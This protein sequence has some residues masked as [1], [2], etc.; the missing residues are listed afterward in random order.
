MNG[1]STLSQIAKPRLPWDALRP[2]G[3][4]L[5]ATLAA[6]A[7]VTALRA[8]IYWMPA[9]PFLLLPV[10]VGAFLGGV[11]S[12]LFGLA[13]VLAVDA[14][15]FWELSYAQPAPA[16]LAAGIPAVWFIA[17]G[18]LLCLAGYWF[19]RAGQS[20]GEL[21]QQRQAL[22]REG[23]RRRNLEESLLRSQTTVKAQLSEIEG[24]FAAAPVGLARVGP[25]LR[26][27][28]INRHWVA[29]TGQPPE[30]QLGRTVEEALPECGAA[31]AACLREVLASGQAA[32]DRE[33]SSAPGSD[34]VWLAGF[35][36][37]SDEDGGVAGV[38]IALRD[39]SAEKRGEAAQR[40]SEET[41]RALAECSPEA[42]W[43]ADAAG[44]P[45]FANRRWFEATGFGLEEAANLGWLS[46]V[47]PEDRERLKERLELALRDG[48]RLETECRVRPL[49]GG[50]FRWHSLRVAPL[51]DPLGSVTSWLLMGADI[52]QA[53]TA[54]ELR[55]EA[56]ARLGLALQAG[57][58]AL[59]A[60]PG[61]HEPAA[62]L[63]ARPLASPIALEGPLQAWID[64]V[65]GGEYEPLPGTEGL[66]T[67]ELQIAG[68]GGASCWVRVAARR[69]SGGAR[70][71][72]TVADITEQKMTEDALG[73]SR[74]ALREAERRQNEFLGV[75]THELRNPLAPI[76][77]SAQ[78][79][80]RRGLERP[81]LLESATG[82]IE[83]Q[84][85]H[86]SRMIGDLADISRI[87]RGKVELQPEILELDSAV[88]Q[89]VE[90][91]RPLLD[92]RRQELFLDLPE[93]P[94]YV[95]ADSIRLAQVISCL[96]D[97]ASKFSP[98][99]G[100]I[101][102]AVGS[103][104]QAAIISVRDEGIGIDP[105]ELERVFE[106]F[107]QLERPLHSGHVGV[108]VGLALA[109]ALLGLQGGEISASSAGK[110]QGS[111]FVIRLPL[112][113]ADV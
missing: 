71:V 113:D 49:T 77:T 48:A 67:G 60:K 88:S 87:G 84:V 51:K 86:L 22:E 73:R 40:Q 93:R 82:S 85:K 52:H 5:L 74:E 21:A 101:Q 61:P 96:L 112:A 95:R 107:V 16:D 94:V 18:L 23:S 34:R 54:E 41:F 39:G 47:H 76:L 46:V 19:R 6:I 11:G 4:V 64:G 68:S 65:Y 8:V 55:R 111:E 79:L 38:D 100:N 37:A 56:E 36:P 42:V 63:D 83:R 33:I 110:G 92:K 2:Y 28:R 70:L 29:V 13:L 90:A 66:Y 106:P 72:G 15:L 69:E 44:A 89:A 81:D 108:G 35:V 78:L 91:S 58:M 12:G 10:L 43:L 103:D 27:G 80:R 32:H 20:S 104:E 26:L 25:D 24:I 50:E 3:A 9:A 97:N 105:A 53:R 17:G 45:I 1:F 57:R 14:L 102:L 31:M 75:L 7:A 98:T 59:W 62:W 30:A 109:K 99:G